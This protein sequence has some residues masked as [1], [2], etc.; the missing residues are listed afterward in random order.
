M[1][2]RERRERE[3]R[4]EKERKKR[5]KEEKKR[6]KLE[7]ELL[8]KR[9]KMKEKDNKKKNNKSNKKTKNSTK[10]NT[11]SNSKNK[12]KNKKNKEPNFIIK[13]LKFILKLFLILILIICLLAGILIGY[14]GVKTGWDKTEMLKLLAKET[15][16]IITGQ[17]QEDIDNLKPI[18]CLVMG[19]SKDID[20]SLT[21]TIMVCAY[22]PKTQ[23]ASMLS[24]P[25]DTFIGDSTYTAS[26]TDKVNSVYAAHGNDP[27]ATLEEVEELTGLD[28]NNYVLIDT[29]ALV[30]LVDEI[31]GVY[32][33]VPID[34]NYDSKNQDLHINLEK[35]YQLIDGEKAE[36]LLRFRKNNDGTGYPAEYGSDDYGRMRTQRDFITETIKQTL[37]LQNVTKIND[38]VNIVFENVDTNLDINEVLNYVPAAVEFDIDNIKSTALPGASERIGPS[39]LWFFLHNEEETE[40]IIDE[41][42][43]FNEKNEGTVSIAPED[44]TIQIL[45]GTGEEYISEEIKNRLS[46]SG[47]NVVKEGVTTITKESKLIN[48][49][50]KSEKLSNQL[51]EVLGDFNIKTG[52]ANDYS[53]DY[54]IIIGQDMI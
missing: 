30:K 32:F 39:G 38:L 19:V 25:R 54:T 20:V 47:Y 1:S 28:I 13:T 4:E 35:G 40:E 46:Q 48:R 24:I 41:M 7:E 27:E 18:Y 36:Q 49:T 16:M 2:R 3:E 42:F 15:T 21:D 45:N 37:R 17:T 50:N 9:Q 8:K 29:N 23:Q 22:Y 52:K 44:L 34:M 10:N 14:L 6:A 43:L 51:N 33:D 31:G 53:I 12:N 26:G 11:K 5:E